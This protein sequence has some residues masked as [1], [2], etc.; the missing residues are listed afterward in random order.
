M[1]SHVWPS[2]D[3]KWFDGEHFIH[4]LFVGNVGDRAVD[5]VLAVKPLYV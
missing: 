4:C 1:P 3:V 2:L 5:E